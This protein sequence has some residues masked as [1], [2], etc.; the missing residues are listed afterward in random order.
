MVYIYLAPPCQNNID[1]QREIVAALSPFMCIIQY[2]S[3]WTSFPYLYTVFLYIG[4]STPW[5][6][7]TLFIGPQIAA[8]C[9]C[10][11]FNI[12]SS[13]FDK[14]TVLSHVCKIWS[15]FFCSK[16]TKLPTRSFPLCTASPTRRGPRSRIHKHAQSV[17][18]VSSESIFE[19]PICFRLIW[20]RS[21]LVLK[22]MR[23]STAGTSSA[24]AAVFHLGVVDA[25][26][27]LEDF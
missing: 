9:S 5:Y 12:L 16:P 24:S 1:V 11:Q 10:S 21:P 2:R 14:Q 26:Q 3:V 17:T 20:R 7:N 23:V 18:F 25:E 27:R 22:V 15:H 6:N 4:Q 8:I 19:L 13:A